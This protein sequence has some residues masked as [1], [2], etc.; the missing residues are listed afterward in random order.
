[1]R[2]IT[3]LAFIVFYLA[4]C[5]G[6]KEPLTVHGK[7]VGHWVAELKQPDAKARKKAV[8]ALGQV[9]KADATAI[10][11]LIGALGDKDQR[12]RNEAVL[13][14]LKLGPDAREALPALEN[15]KA[16]RNATVREYVGKAIARIRGE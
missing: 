15:A 12:V 2:R 1:M 3:L 7:P 13:A 10:P 9:G 11:A 14:L 16:D 8:A 6:K 5:A 4:G